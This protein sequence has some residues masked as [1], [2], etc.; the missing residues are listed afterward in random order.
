MTSARVIIHPRCLSG[1]AVG[2]LEAVLRAHGFAA[3][4]LAVGPPSKRGYCDLVRLVD[5]DDDLLTLERMDGY[6]FRHRIKPEDPQA[7]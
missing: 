6:R 3:G 5:K 7:A 4:E 1:P 2:A